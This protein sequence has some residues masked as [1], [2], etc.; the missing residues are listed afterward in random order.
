MEMRHF[1]VETKGGLL[2]DDFHDKEAAKVLCRQANFSALM[3]GDKP[4]PYINATKV[5]DSAP[6]NDELGIVTSR[7]G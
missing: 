6:W 5:S 1:V 2:A 7:R 3:M 4:A